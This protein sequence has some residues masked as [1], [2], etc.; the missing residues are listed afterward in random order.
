MDKMQAG[1]NQT[2]AYYID[3]MNQIDNQNKQVEDAKLQYDIAYEVYEYA[4]TPYLQAEGEESSRV[5]AKQVYE[6]ALAKFTDSETRYNQLKNELAVDSDPNWR[7]RY[8]EAKINELKNNPEYMSR[9]TTYEN[10]VDALV[11]ASNLLQAVEQRTQSLQASVDAKKSEVDTYVSQMF[12]YLSTDKMIEALGEDL[13]EEFIGKMGSYSFNNYLYAMDRYYRNTLAQVDKNGNVAEQLQRIFSAGG[14]GDPYGIMGMLQEVSGGDIET[15]NGATYTVT[16]CYPNYNAQGEFIG[17]ETCVNTVLPDNRK[18]L[19]YNMLSQNAATSH[20]HQSLGEGYNDDTLTAVFSKLSSY[21][22]QNLM[23]QFD[24]YKN[25]SDLYLQYL[26]M[27]NR[28]GAVGK[29][30]SEI[31]G[32]LEK[33]KDVFGNNLWSPGYF[34]MTGT[35]YK[36]REHWYQAKAQPFYKVWLGEGH[37]IHNYAMARWRA[38]VDWN[39]RVPNSTRVANVEKYTHKEKLAYQDLHSLRTALESES[40]FQLNLADIDVN[41]PAD[42]NQLRDKLAACLGVYNQQGEYTKAIQIIGALNADNDLDKLLLS[43]TFSEVTLRGKSGYENG[44]IDFSYMLSSAVKILSGLN[45]RSIGD[46][47]GYMRENNLDETL[48]LRERLALISDKAWGPSESQK[49]SVV[50][51]NASNLSGIPNTSGNLTTTMSFYHRQ[52]SIYNTLTQDMIYGKSQDYENGYEEGIGQ[53]S[54]QLMISQQVRLKQQEWG[55]KQSEFYQDQ[56][57]WKEKVYEIFDR[58]VAAWDQELNRF[59]SEWQTWIDTTKNKMTKLESAAKVELASFDKKAADWASKSYENAAKGIAVEFSQDQIDAVKSKMTEVIEKSVDFGSKEDLKTQIDKMSQDVLSKTSSL[60]IPSFMF[61]KAKMADT[62]FTFSMMKDNNLLGAMQNQMGATLNQYQATIA[63]M[64]N[65][66]IMENMEKLVKQSRDSIIKQD[67]EYFDKV[68]PGFM[69]REFGYQFNGSS[70]YREV[71]ESVT[72]IGVDY[73]TQY[74]GAYQKYKVPDVTIDIKVLNKDRDVVQFSPSSVVELSDIEMN[75]VYDIATAQVNLQIEKIEKEFQENVDRQISSDEG[76]KG[77]IIQAVEAQEEER[78]KAEAGFSASFW[79]I[80][81]AP[82]FPLSIGSI[83]KIAASIVLTATGA[84]ALL[85]A[86]IMATMSFTESIA[87][88]NNFWSA[89]GGATMQFA[90]SMIPGGDTILGSIASNFAKSTLNN[91]GG[92][93]LSGQGFSS[94]KDFGNMMAGSAVQGIA[95]GLTSTIGKG[96]FLGGREGGFWSNLGSTVIRDTTTGALGGISNRLVSGEGFDGWKDFGNVVGLGAAKGAI[97][98]TA[99]GLATGVVNQIRIAGNGKSQWDVVNQTRNYQKG[100]A[101][102]TFA[103]NLTDKAINGI[104]NVFTNEIDRVSLKYEMKRKNPKISDAEIEKALNDKGDWKKAVMTQTSEIIVSGVKDLTI[105]GINGLAD[106]KWSEKDG[107]YKTDEGKSKSEQQYYNNSLQSFAGTLGEVGGRLGANLVINAIANNDNYK[108]DVYKFKF[109]HVTDTLGF[110]WDA[111][112][113]KT[114]EEEKKAEQDAAN[115]KTEEANTQTKINVDQKNEEVNAQTQ[116]NGG[117]NLKKEKTENGFLSSV[118]NWLVT[119]GK[120]VGNWFVT[121]GK[122]L[123]ATITGEK[124]MEVCKNGYDSSGRCTDK[125]RD[126]FDSTKD[127]NGT[128]EMNFFQAYQY[129]NEKNRNFTHN[130]QKNPYDIWSTIKSFAFKA[131]DFE[132]AV[133]WAANEFIEDRYYFKEKN[134]SESSLRTKKDSELKASEERIKELTK[135]ALDKDKYELKKNIYSRIY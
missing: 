84:G 61:D 117:Q 90:T 99:R 35:N 125:G 16:N 10:Q 83:T 59:K 69:N 27:M 120:N 110:L 67:Q 12:G 77:I 79:D 13:Y 113:K 107:K 82:G 111:G 132:A 58:G 70:Y 32:F 54:F 33:Y 106:T 105:M 25:Y 74:I 19:I 119:A 44:K 115:K 20:V 49:I 127:G 68:V 104:G 131:D 1:L 133:G 46:M 123:W 129:Y 4:N 135:K 3:L 47:K 102:N 62:N 86:G 85:A 76:A 45:S 36:A 38:D 31:N 130:S 134:I 98:G 51:G 108:L 39:Y 121:A 114:V 34:H 87:R 17:G 56:N 53:E 50:L 24:F 18:Q 11:S 92:R 103:A 63:K 124:K 7:A 65:L 29:D 42:L 52:S 23:G 75:T 2:H 101:W 93:L 41:D 78:I 126:P 8:V 60:G 88:G 26:G 22:G 118:G 64:N 5:D 97:S 28:G 128:S 37:V 43:Q 95:G 112:A 72:L 80:P 100:S 14:T 122:N 40:K 30:S 89:L 15:W 55:I 109:S 71:V 57:Q 94:W 66:K 73:K 96:D 91:V 9:W 116:A 81:I 6:E 48:F 21:Q